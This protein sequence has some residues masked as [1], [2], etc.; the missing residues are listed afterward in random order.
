MYPSLVLPIGNS[1]W[2]PRAAFCSGNAIDERTVTIHAPL[3]LTINGGS[4][5]V[6][7]KFP[8]QA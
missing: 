7:M 1:R 4:H 2:L 3:L 6:H 5:E 8:I